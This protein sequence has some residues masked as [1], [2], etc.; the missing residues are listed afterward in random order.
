[1]NFNE[2]FDEAMLRIDLLL[3]NDYTPKNIKKYIEAFKLENSI[4]ARNKRKIGE[5]FLNQSINSSYIL[6][7]KRQRQTIMNEIRETQNRFNGTRSRN[8]IN[9]PNSKTLMNQDE[10]LLY[11]SN[12]I[13]KKIR[14]F[15]P[16]NSHKDINN[17]LFMSSNLDSNE[18]SKLLTKLNIDK[19]E[20]RNKQ[21]TMELDVN[22]L[23]NIN[24]IDLKKKRLFSSNG[25]TQRDKI[26]NLNY[27][28][29]ILSESN[30]KFKSSSL[31]P[32]QKPIQTY[33]RKK[34][35]RYNIDIRTPLEVR[36][37]YLHQKDKLFPNRKKIYKKEINS[38]SKDKYYNHLN[39]LQYKADDYDIQAKREA[40]LLK[41]RNKYDLEGTNKVSNLLYDSI[42]T[43][44]A[45]LNQIQR[46]I[47]STNRKQFK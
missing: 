45:L 28:Q 33:E 10:E 19:I 5:S 4:E 9:R 25:I 17:N 30:Y 13:G 34:E 26:E 31:K 3:N 7:D 32:K 18:Y 27:K 22:N 8:I 12:T 40:H 21:R 11:N 44:F 36:P 29:K 37:D 15:S 42:S 6:D 43:K 1:M 47:N 20:Q 16:I 41:L 2:K 23:N 38:N 39:E 46:D 24:N 35:N 14:I